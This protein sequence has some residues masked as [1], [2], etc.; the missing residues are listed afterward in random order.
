MVAR[1]VA[2]DRPKSPLQCGRQFPNGCHD[3]SAGKVFRIEGI[4]LTT[5]ALTVPALISPSRN[6]RDEIDYSRAQCGPQEPAASIWLERRHGHGHCL[7]QHITERFDLAGSR[8]KGGVFFTAA[9]FA[10]QDKMDFGAGNLHRLCRPGGASR[11]APAGH[12]LWFIGRPMTLVFSNALELFAIGGAVFTVNAI[13]RGVLFGGRLL[14][15]GRAVN[16][17]DSGR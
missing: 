12:H 7:H 1:N 13:A 15:R 17:H 16:R 5:A 4:F 10:R 9:Y 11:C 6:R 8:R 3:G 14:C 2:A